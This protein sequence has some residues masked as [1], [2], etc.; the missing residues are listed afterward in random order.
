MG[1]YIGLRE[2]LSS[3]ASDHQLFAKALSKA[4]DFKKMNSACAR[5]SSPQS[6]AWI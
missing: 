1:N 6:G 4:I 3:N 5:T 2:N